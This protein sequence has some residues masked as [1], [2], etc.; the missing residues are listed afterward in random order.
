[1][2]KS[3]ATYKEQFTAIPDPLKK[4]VFIRL[5]LALMF[6]SVSILA[7]VSMFDWMAIIPLICLA[8]YST[9][10]AGALFSRAVARKY[11]VIQGRCTEAIVTP[12]RRRSKSVLVQTNEHMVRLMIKQRLRRILPGVELE[13]YVADNTQVYEKDGAKLLHAYLA[14][15]ITHSSN[16]PE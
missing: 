8:I 11:V 7:I 5:G 9:F 10:S 6:L 16:T 3:I 4:Q 12:I 13:I 1:M 2:N 15:N 14:I